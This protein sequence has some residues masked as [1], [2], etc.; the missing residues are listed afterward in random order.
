MAEPK[1]EG[2]S[3]QDWS[4]FQLRYRPQTPS[5]TD[6]TGQQPSPTATPGVPGNVA[7]GL[8]NPSPAPQPTLQPSPSPQIG[9]GNTNDVMPSPQRVT[10]DPLQA[11]TPSMPGV[12]G[13]GGAP[14]GGNI[15]GQPAQQTPQ[16]QMQGM[17]RSSIMGLLNTNVNSASVQDAD[18][19]PQSQAFAAAQQQA[20]AKLRAQ[21]VHQAQRGGYGTSGGLDQRLDA[22]TQQTGQA[23]GAHDAALIGQKLDTRRQQLNMALSQAQQLGMADEANNLQRQLANLDA[24]VQTRGQDINARGQD[25][26]SN[27]ANLDASTRIYLGDLN[28]QMQQAGI[29]AQE[30][31]AAMDAEL[32]RYGI[33]MQGRLGDLDAALR[34][35]GLDLEYDRLGVNV[36]GM[37]Q[38][39]NRDAVL[40]GLGG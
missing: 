34:N 2:M 28:A 6:A 20:E 24:S 5:P 29:S 1:P 35:R 23:I 27:L 19:A 7:T 22:L 33:D 40:A 31:A 13:T 37:Q 36:A 39:M 30:R 8:K 10:G 11:A 38:Q 17:L 14:S 9:L 21:A 32:R 15:A 25:L 16:Q 4:N 12:S 26:Q 3:D 18:L